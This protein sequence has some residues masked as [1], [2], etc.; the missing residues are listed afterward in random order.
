MPSLQGYT[1][2]PEASETLPKRASSRLLV[3]TCPYSRGYEVITFNSGSAEGQLRSTQAVKNSRT[4]ELK[5]S[6]TQ[7]LKNSRT[8]EEPTVWRRGPH[9]SIL[10]YLST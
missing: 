8:Q 5:N 10:E 4:Q 3:P 6:R 1:S 9:R 2:L 7:E